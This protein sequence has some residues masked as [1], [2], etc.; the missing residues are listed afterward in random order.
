MHISTQLAHLQLRWGML[1]ILLAYF[2][3]VQN[4]RTTQIKAA[5]PRHSCL[6]MVNPNSFMQ[7]TVPTGPGR[8]ASTT[9]GMS[10]QVTVVVGRKEGR[11]G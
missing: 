1:T 11:G 8:K 10:L 2:T 4:F 3:W 6:S 9:A 5:R 7:V